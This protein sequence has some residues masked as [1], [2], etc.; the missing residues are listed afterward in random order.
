M[1]LTV[2]IT[3]SAQEALDSRHTIVSPSIH[4]P[5]MTPV[6]NGNIRYFICCTVWEGTKRHG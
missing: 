5:D 6:R 1:L 3:A 4:P 2:G